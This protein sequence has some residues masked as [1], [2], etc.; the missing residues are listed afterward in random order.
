M[1]NYSKVLLVTAAIFG[2]VGTVIG[3][4]M[5]GAGSYAFRP[6]HAHILVSGFLALSVFALF[7]KVF[8]PKNQLLSTIHV[9]TAIIGNVGLVVGMYLHFLLDLPNAATLPV[10][11]GGGVILL[12]SYAVFLI[13]TITLDTRK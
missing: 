8:T 7:Y 1:K 11:I 4:H 10:Y 13:Q 6:I 5:A 2:L 9:W 3:A 12:V